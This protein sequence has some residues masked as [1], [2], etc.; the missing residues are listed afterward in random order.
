MQGNVVYA[1]ELFLLFDNQKI[2]IHGNDSTNFQ[3]II[4]FNWILNSILNPLRDVDKGVGMNLPQS[5]LPQSYA[6]I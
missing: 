5:T 1:I 3:A 6:A 2:N 4:K